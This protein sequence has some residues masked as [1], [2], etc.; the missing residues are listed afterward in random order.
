MTGEPVVEIDASGVAHGVL[1][2]VFGIA[3]PLQVVRGV[4][5]LPAEASQIPERVVERARVVGASAN[6]EIEVEGEPR[7]LAVVVEEAVRVDGECGT[8]SVPEG[9]LE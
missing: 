1:D 7:T 9:R 4:G 5:L 8:C 2:V 3:A 6:E